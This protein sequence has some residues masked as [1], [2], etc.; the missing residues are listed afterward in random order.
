MLGGTVADGQPQDRS[1]ATKFGEIRF[2]RVAK[3]LGAEGFYIED[4]NQLSPV[5]EKA[6]NTNTVTIIH[7]P[8]QLA[9]IQCWEERFGG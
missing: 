9:A 4:P 1:I 3:A 7:V 6:L 8:T 2:D 5:I